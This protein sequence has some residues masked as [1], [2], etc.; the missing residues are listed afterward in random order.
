M[1]ANVRKPRTLRTPWPP[2]ED[3][4]KVQSVTQ[5]DNWQSLKTQFKRCDAWDIIYYNF[6]TYNPEEVNWYLREWIGCHDL[7]HDGE[8]FRFGLLPNGQP[9]KIYIPVDDWLPPGPEQAKTKKMAIQILRE[10]TAATLAFKAGPLELK[11]YDLLSVASAIEHERIRVV[12]RPCLGHFSQYDGWP[13]HNRLLLSFGGA[14]DL[15]MRALMVHEAVHAAM[16]IR[17]VPQTMQQAEALSYIAQA[18]YSRRN[19]YDLGNA[20]PVPSFQV[21]PVNYVPWRELYKFAGSIA[22]DIDNGNPVDNLDLIGLGISI[23]MAPSYWHEP[24][25]PNDGI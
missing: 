4:L 9:M 17:A 22:A 10:V 14:P 21:D 3:L 1:S 20:I 6:A 19:G 13:K 24:A 16:D 2:T 15:G 23:T 8:N 7:S 11:R 25:P 18:L 12:H 5:A